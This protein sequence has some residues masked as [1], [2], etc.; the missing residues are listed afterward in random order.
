MLKGRITAEGS[1]LVT[2][3]YQLKMEAPDKKMRLTDVMDTEQVLRLIQSIPSK[4]AE[5]LRC[6]LSGLVDNPD[7]QSLLR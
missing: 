3:C 2:K 4:K 7:A 6:G 1:E 5:P